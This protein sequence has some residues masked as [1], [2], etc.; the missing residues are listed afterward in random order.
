[1]LNGWFFVQ[2]SVGGWLREIL[3][4][5][6]SAVLNGLDIP[7]S[8]KGKCIAWC[9]EPLNQEK[10]PL[11]S[12]PVGQGIHVPYHAKKAVQG[13]FVET[14][15]KFLTDKLGS[16]ILAVQNEASGSGGKTEADK[17]VVASEV[18]DDEEGEVQTEPAHKRRRA[19]RYWEQLEYD[20][21][22][23]DSSLFPDGK[24]RGKFSDL[25]E[26]AGSLNQLKHLL[27]AYCASDWD[28]C[29][30]LVRKYSEKHEELVFHRHSLKVRTTR[31]I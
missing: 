5:R 15:V 20:Q 29:D 28:E 16:P 6:H 9:P 31:D 8:A 7:A 27:R 25:G 19:D 1:M 23:L 21:P 4:G 26:G 12:P 14:T 10:L 18:H 11:Y 22:D 3:K 13:L 17:A 30:Q 24:Y 2:G